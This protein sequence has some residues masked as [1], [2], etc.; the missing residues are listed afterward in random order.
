MEFEVSC[1]R[2]FAPKTETAILVPVFY[3]GL[4]NLTT[5]RTHR[6]RNG[7]RERILRFVAQNEALVDIARVR[8]NRRIYKARL[9]TLYISF[10]EI[11]DFHTNRS[12]LHVTLCLTALPFSGE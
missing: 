7:K 8:S 6:E 12:E 10:L 2:K 9:F 5:M 4:G 11:V 3:N 1:D